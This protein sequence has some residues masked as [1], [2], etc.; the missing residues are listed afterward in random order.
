MYPLYAIAPN[1]RSWIYNIYF[2]SSFPLNKNNTILKLGNKDYF[3]IIS[4]LPDTGEQKIVF[5]SIQI[6]SSNTYIYMK[7][8][9]LASFSKKWSLSK[10]NQYSLFF[11]L[12]KKINEPTVYLFNLPYRVK[13]IQL[14]NNNKILFNEVPSISSSGKKY[15]L[16]KLP[17]TNKNNKFG[18]T[19]SLFSNTQ[20]T[21]TELSKIRY[22]IKPNIQQQLTIKKIKPIYSQNNDTSYQ[23]KNN[24]I[25][26]FVVVVLVFCFII[27]IT[28]KLFNRINITYYGYFSLRGIVGV[29]LKYS[30][31]VKY[32]FLFFFCIGLIFDVFYLKSHDLLVISMLIFFWGIISI[33]YNLSAHFNFLF[34]LILLS[35]SAFQS[36]INDP[37]W[38]AEKLALWSYLFFC[39]GLIYLIINNLIRQKKP[40]CYKSFLIIYTSKKNSLFYFLKYIMKSG[41]KVFCAKKI[42][43][44]TVLYIIIFFIISIW[45]FVFPKLGTIANSD[46]FWG[47]NAYNYLEKSMY[48]WY[49]MLNGGVYS[50]SPYIYGYS[51]ATLLNMLNVSF[52]NPG[53]ILL[54]MF[55][56]WIVIYRLTLLILN[57]DIDDWKKS[58]I[59]LIL[60]SFILANEMFR[61]FLIAN[62][63]IVWGIFFM[64]LTIY[65]YLLYFYNNQLKY[66]IISAFSISFSLIDFHSG[67]LAGIF[68]FCFT[69]INIFISLIS[70]KR[71]SISPIKKIF[72]FALF[73]LLLNNHWIINNIYNEKNYYGNLKQYT[74]N[75]SS[76]NTIL[77]AYNSYNNLAANLILTTKNSFVKNGFYYIDIAFSFFIILLSY[78]SLYYIKRENNNKKVIYFALFLIIFTS[79]SFGPKNP[80][81][82]FT[83][84]WK[85]VPG[86]ILFRDFFKFHRLLVLSYIILSSY[87]V[88]SFIKSK[89]K[90]YRF[91]I[92]LLLICMSYKL[93]YLSKF[94]LYHPFRIPPYYMKLQNYLSKNKVDSHITIMPILST[95]QVYDWPG[96][97]YYDIQ[98]PV[99]YFSPQPIYVNTAIFTETFNDLVNKKLVL[100]LA[101]KQFDLFL[102]LTAIKNIQL[103]IIRNDLDK[104]FIKQKLST[105]FLY[106]EFLDTNTLNQN[107]Q[108]N[109]TNKVDSLGKLKI[110]KLKP[111]LFLPHFYI[112]NTVY[113][114]DNYEKD[115]FYS[116]SK[117]AI[118]LKSSVYFK[119]QNDD[120]KLK[121][122]TNMIPPSQPPIVE[123]KKINPTKYRVVIHQATTPFPLIFSESYHEGWK[124]YIVKN[125]KSLSTFN[126][127]SYKVFINN[128]DDQASKEEVMEFIK[129]NLISTLGSQ[130]S[131][132]FISKNMKG[133]IQNDNLSDGH[134][135]E[136]WL[137]K[138]LDQQTHLQV[139]GYANSWFINPKQLCSSSFCRKNNNGSYDFDM[140][141][142][143][144]PQ[145]LFLIC[146]IISLVTIIGSIIYLSKKSNVKKDK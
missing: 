96:K 102:K 88:I 114:Y 32:P 90:Y 84:L 93:Y 82:I 56:I 145:R 37:N 133:T 109:L 51:L 132:N 78:L 19:L 92:V 107:A 48:T 106:S 142:E 26:L 47:I 146:L 34:S 12:S 27:Y 129:N 54:V 9:S 111:S 53:I 101:N 69:L 144:W 124:A 45:L 89:K 138:P 64:F 134:L 123:F 8:S 23:K 58:S 80:L 18:F 143:F 50:A 2:S 122:L 104:T 81:G 125:T 67:L 100:Y 76:T 59:V 42:F 95:H 99:R 22:T 16:R 36:I 136:A 55:G 86:F 39:Y 127:N 35:L 121:I 70:G 105:E 11:T 75:K 52:S 130:N 61:V 31:I 63:T 71:N 20:L 25:F 79:F 1:N 139:N 17:L 15:F 108:A 6:N 126:L 28:Y 135:F 118:N 94:S 128:E 3:P 43:K 91:I 141:I 65:L 74:Q 5:N 137:T 116:M 115:F 44:K 60:S 103:I 117:L 73:T 87:T 10:K 30:K 33:G 113:Y 72:I 29:I 62:I 119:N 77:E 38:K 85:N 24:Y 83:F 41:K 7:I 97:L 21:Q 4:Q 46:G 66:L 57:I 112:P 98:D 110:Y 140:I 120:D 14:E 13:L 49:D 131:I 68:I 40:V